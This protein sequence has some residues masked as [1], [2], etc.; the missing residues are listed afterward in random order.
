MTGTDILLHILT[1]FDAI[2]HR[3]HNI[4]YNDVNFIVFQFFQSFFTISG[5]QRIEEFSKSAAKI[6]ADFIIVFYNK[7]SATLLVTAFDRFVFDLFRIN[8][9]HFFRVGG[10]YLTF[11]IQSVIRS[12]LGG[13]IGIYVLWQI[14]RESTAFTLF[15]IQFDTTMVQFYQTLYQ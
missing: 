11:L 1:Q 8:E 3:H 4:S 14:D 13:F 7:N 9:I 2:H 10:I 15:T 6:M 5:F 12:Q